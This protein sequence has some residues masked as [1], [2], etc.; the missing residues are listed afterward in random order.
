M[1]LLKCQRCKQ[2]VH[3]LINDLCE[4][5]QAALR[6]RFEPIRQRFLENLRGIRKDEKT[7]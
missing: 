7:R 3:F 5:C 2:E 4:G 6:R 1:K